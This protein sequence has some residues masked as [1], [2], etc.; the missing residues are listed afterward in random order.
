MLF[1]NSCNLSL[2]HL[3]NDTIKIEEPYLRE[4][5]FK[6][7]LRERKSNVAFLIALFC[8]LAFYMENSHAL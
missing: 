6:T 1:L 8:Y 7:T 4:F 5:I 3:D 2:E